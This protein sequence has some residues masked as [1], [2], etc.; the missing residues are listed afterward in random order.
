MRVQSLRRDVSLVGPNDRARVSVS[1]K[2][3]KV[4]NLPK[5][6][7][8]AAI[9]RQVREVNIGSKAVVE[10]HMNDVTVDQLGL[11]Q[12]WCTSHDLMVDGLLQRLNSEQGLVVACTLPVGS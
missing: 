4:L 5:R 7:E 12:K 1:T 10:T 6:L 3:A 11:D 8:Y 2:P 9:V